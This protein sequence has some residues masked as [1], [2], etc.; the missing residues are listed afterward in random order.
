MWEFF[1]DSSNA[2]DIQELVSAKLAVVPEAK[3]DDR[4]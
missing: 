4:G 2:I 1:T 3:D